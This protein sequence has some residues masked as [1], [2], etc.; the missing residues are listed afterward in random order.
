MLVAGASSAHAHVLVC[1]G[2]AELVR[3]PSGVDVYSP[4]LLPDGLDV[5][6]VRLVDC[7]LATE[8]IVRTWAAER[9][10][11]VETHADH[12]V[13]AP[14]GVR[15]VAV[16][17]VSTGSGKTALTRRV[18]RTLA[19]SGIAVSVLRHPIASLLHWGRFDVAAVRTPP[20]LSVP[21]P[22]DEREELAPVVGTGVPVVTGLDPDR[23]VATAAREAGPGGV[24][25]W[26][27]GGAARPWLEPDLHVVAVDLLRPP[28]ERARGRIARAHAVVLTKADSAPGDRAREVEAWVREIAPEVPIVL[29]DLTVGVQPTNVLADKR[30]VIVEDA[31]S[32]LLG[33]LSAGAGAVAARRFRC[34]VVDPRPF[35][36]GTIANALRTHDH[37]GAVIP[38]L[39]RTQRQIDDLAASVYATPGDAVLWA[40]NSDP[41]YIVPDE[42]RSIVRA[43]G[44]LTEVAGASLQSIL[45]PFLPGHQ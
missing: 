5:D 15:V 29:A 23:L 2:V 21:R 6:R 41:A 1:E 4:D 25:V 43:Y 17:A 20:E 24:I 44:E 32:L 34:G 36:V 22:I 13:R 39:G 10:V 38:S 16:S 12:T 18:A 28:G 27:G 8:T 35:A 19:R 14:D 7:E 40:S 31:A 33:G 45:S 9:G 11:P 42:T 26:D 3:T 30:V 37:I